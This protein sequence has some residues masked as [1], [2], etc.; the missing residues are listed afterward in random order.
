MATNIFNYNGTLATTIADGSIDN[1]TSIAMPGRGYINY[2]EPVNQDLLWIMQNFANSSAP[3][4]PTTGQI[5]YNTSNQGLYVYNGST[6]ASAGGAIVS[7]VNPGAGAQA[8]TFWYDS[9]NLQLNV[10]DGTA[11]DI[12]G[13][14]GSATN[15][16]PLNP[17]T[18]SVTS[19]QLRVV[20]I[21]DTLS[22]V[23][24]AWE[25]YV[26]GTLLAIF[27]KDAS[28][29]PASTITGFATIGPGM[30]FSTI[31]SNA[32]VIS[33]SNFTSLQSN[34]PATDN[35]Y[36]MG[37]ASYRFA[38]MYAVNFIG[39]ASSA[40][41][42]DLAERY[43]A[44][45]PLD[46]GTVVSL[47]G[48]AEVTASTTPGSEDVFGVV[49]TNPAYLMNSAAGDAS[50][51]PAIAMTGRVPCKVV[52]PVKKGQRLMASSVTGCA[53]AYDTSMGV[54]SILGRSLVD[55][56]TDSIELIEIVVGK[57]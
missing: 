3:T 54:L 45:A 19:S 38:N 53:C 34:L 25:L 20:R 44:D 6:W 52:G 31:V 35:L 33:S 22:V 56:T 14:L 49:S 48:D 18:S 41:Y 57:N 40:L 43:A 10:W 27:S 1:T 37:S 28:Y 30:N 9:T 7:T 47:G 36:N 2:G 12:V 24:S 50:Q 23:H 32:G 42:A 55:K 51:Y 11:W 29:T 13:P 5:W 26:A 16:D 4:N 39:Q 21:T 46:P 15:T 8:G 17:S